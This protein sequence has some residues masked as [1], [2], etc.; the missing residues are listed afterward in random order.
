MAAIDRAGGGVADR[1][2]GARH[3]LHGEQHPFDVRVLDDRL[4]PDVAP[5][6]RPCFLSRA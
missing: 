2:R 6:A 5:S 1:A 3:C 4:D